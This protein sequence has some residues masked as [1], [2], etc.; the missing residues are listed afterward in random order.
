GHEGFGEN[1][2]PI[3]H[4]PLPTIHIRTYTKNNR[5]IIAI[6]N[7]GPVIEAELIKRI[8]DPFFT[9]KPLGKGTGLGLSISY[10]IIV[11]E[12]G[13]QLSC[14]SKVGQGTEFAIELPAVIDNSQS[15]SKASANFHSRI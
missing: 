5:V 6:A 13:G 1:S 14:N 7:N 10:K 11:E 2:L 4:Y 15:S 8:F 3:T 12:H 9:T